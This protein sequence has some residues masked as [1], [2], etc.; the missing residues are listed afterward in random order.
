MRCTNCDYA[1]NTEAVRVAGARRRSR[2]TACRRR[3]VARHARHADDRRRWSTSSTPAPTC[4]A[5]TATWTAADTLKNV[6][7]KLRHPDGTRRAAGDRRARRPRGRPEAARGAGRARPRSS[8]SPRPT[9][10]RTR[11]W[12]RAT[13]G[14]VRSAPTQPSGIRYLVDPRVVDGTRVGHRRR[15]ARAA[16]CSTSSP[17]ATSPPDG[18]IEAAEVRDGDACPT[19]GSAARDRPRH[20]DRPHLPARPQVRRG[21][22][23]HRARPERQAGHGRRW[24][25]TAS[26]CRGAWRRSP[27]STLRRARA[28]A[29]RARSP[30]PTCTSS[31][32]ARPAARSWPAAE[33]LAGRLE[34]AGLRGAARRP[35]RRVARRQVQGRRADRR[36]D[37]RRRRPRP[38]RQAPT[39][40][41]KDRRSGERV[42]V[43]LADAVAHLVAS[44]RP[45]T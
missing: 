25:P 20:R 37:D 2:S 40:E 21:A 12:S 44:L 22:R 35:R 4:A 29:G 36:A 16:T 3:V 43:A 8:R 18:T 9:S 33:T 38:R 6:V 45:L 15:P 34:A 32:P 5:P 26:A 17:A 41:V 31:S 10:P 11:R 19:C 27:R 42:D 24:A 13:S 1:A 39:I 23:P 30:R 14:P 28:C 7:V